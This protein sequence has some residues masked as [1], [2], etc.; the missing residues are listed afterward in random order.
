VPPEHRSTG[1]PFHCAPLHRSES[2]EI[3][4]PLKGSSPEIGI[5]IAVLSQSPINFARRSSQ[6]STL[7]NSLGVK[8]SDHSW[9]G[10]AKLKI[11]NR[12]SGPQPSF[13]S[14]RCRRPM[15][16]QYQPGF[17]SITGFA[18]F[19]HVTL[20]AGILEQEQTA[21]TENGRNS[22]T[23]V[24]SCKELFIRVRPR[25]LRAKAF[26]ILHPPPSL[27]K[28]ERPCGPSVMP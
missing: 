7:Q 16:P 26:S 8:S 3:G 25:D 18:F 23:S 9:R 22:V 14:G 12:T 10:M 20:D 6:N 1:G 17:C 15:R 2:S 28:G 11:G 24:F 13:P 4:F 19:R 27:W 5:A 21:R